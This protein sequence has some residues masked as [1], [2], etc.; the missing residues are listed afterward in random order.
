MEVPE[1]RHGVIQGPWF[2]S[3]PAALMSEELGDRWHGLSL[4]KLCLCP[5]C[6]RMMAPAWSLSFPL[7]KLGVK[8]RP[9]SPG[10]NEGGRF[11]LGST[12]TLGR[13]SHVGGLAGS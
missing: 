7:V 1:L 5:S 3:L 4:K 9:C 6:S 11:T 13:G 10:S 12:E 8:A 2:W